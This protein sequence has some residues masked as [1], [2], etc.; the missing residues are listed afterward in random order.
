M[1]NKA[2]WVAC[3][4]VCEGVECSIHVDEKIDSSCLQMSNG[5]SSIQLCVNLSLLLSVSLL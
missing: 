2:T 4:G 1:K 3:M 5:G